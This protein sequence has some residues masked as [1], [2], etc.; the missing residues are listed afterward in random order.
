MRY[1]RCALLCS[2]MLPE[3]SSYSQTIALMH[4]RNSLRLQQTQALLIDQDSQSDESTKKRET[5]LNC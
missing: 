2:G 3:Y 1:S 5:P 4:S